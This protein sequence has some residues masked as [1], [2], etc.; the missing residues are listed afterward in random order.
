MLIMITRSESIFIS[1]AHFVDVDSKVR[2]KGAESHSGPVNMGDYQDTFN[3]I[4]GSD[5][6]D[7]DLLNNEFM[8]VVVYEID[9]DWNL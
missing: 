9:Q 8:N 1:G 2:D 5:N 3:F 4:L 6:K 7:L